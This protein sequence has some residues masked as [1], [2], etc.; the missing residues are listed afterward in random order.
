MV[1]EKRWDQPGC[2]LPGGQVARSFL[3]TDIGFVFARPDAIKEWRT[4]FS[5]KDV[6]GQDLSWA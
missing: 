6:A 1:L 5:K 2:T 3:N 4:S